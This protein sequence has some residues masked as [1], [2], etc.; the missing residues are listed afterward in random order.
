MGIELIYSIYHLKHAIKARSKEFIKWT[1]F[2]W[3]SLYLHQKIST[4]LFCKQNSLIGFGSSV[5]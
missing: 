1:T 5:G 2:A 3:H 4:C